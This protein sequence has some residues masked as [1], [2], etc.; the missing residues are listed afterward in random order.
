MFFLS[1]CATVHVIWNVPKMAPPSIVSRIAI[2]ENVMGLTPFPPLASGSGQLQE[3]MPYPVRLGIGKGLAACVFN[4]A[5][6]S[7][8]FLALVTAYHI[9]LQ[10][11]I[12]SVFK[13]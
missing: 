9:F 3:K 2:S 6:F 8:Y 13:A 5:S 1:F 12:K 10:K 7:C 11:A 4:T